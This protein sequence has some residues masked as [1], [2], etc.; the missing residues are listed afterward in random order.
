MES[1]G[2][3]IVVFLQGMSGCTTWDMMICETCMK[4]ESNEASGCGDGYAG[5]SLS[6]HPNESGFKLYRNATILW[7]VNTP[8]L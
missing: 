2:N 3:V 4:S 7:Y 6:M 1:Y 5:V 8:D